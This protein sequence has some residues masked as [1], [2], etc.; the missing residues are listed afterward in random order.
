[1]GENYGF[2]LATNPYDSVEVYGVR[3]PADFKQYDMTLPLVQAL[4]SCAHLQTPDDS[5]CARA[6]TMIGEARSQLVVDA[7]SFLSKVGPASAPSSQLYETA[8]S[9]IR[10]R[11]RLLENFA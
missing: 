3:I 9:Y 1:M 11:I 5:C 10:G 8:T 2:A 6:N 7:N 4:G